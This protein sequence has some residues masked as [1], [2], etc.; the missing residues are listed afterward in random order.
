MAKEKEKACVADSIIFEIPVAE[1]PPQAYCST[2]LDLNLTHYQ[3]QNLKR[4]VAGLDQAG[5]RLLSGTRVVT[6]PD[7]VRFLLER[8]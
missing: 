2:R 4:I 3:A 1:F 5:A 6:G 7:A 8:A